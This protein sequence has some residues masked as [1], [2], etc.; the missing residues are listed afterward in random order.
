VLLP[1]LSLT[2]E[3]GVAQSGRR[4]RLQTVRTSLFQLGAIVESLV[5]SYAARLEVEQYRARATAALPHAFQ[6]LT[7]PLRAEMAN[8]ADLYMTICRTIQFTRYCLLLPTSLFA[9][10]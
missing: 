6:N 4:H 1:K 7:Q 10:Y 9:L 3:Y 5:R 2:A 8:L